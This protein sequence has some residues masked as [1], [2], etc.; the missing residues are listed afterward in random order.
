M[1]ARP[2]NGALACVNVSSTSVMRLFGAKRAN[3]DAHT[4]TQNCLLFFYL[5]L[6]MPPQS[7]QPVD[8]LCEML[9][10]DVIVKGGTC[11]RT[12]AGSYQLRYQAMR[13]VHLHQVR[14]HH[15]AARKKEKGACEAAGMQSICRSWMN[16]ITACQKISESSINSITGSWDTITVDSLKWRC[17]NAW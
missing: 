15:G 5:L 2:Y 17:C 1:Q 16:L 7:L 3:I 4:H 14:R 6:Q 9:W 11:P 8:V 10:Q 13:R 12:E